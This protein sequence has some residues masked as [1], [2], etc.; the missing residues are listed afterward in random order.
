MEVARERLQG[1]HF[2]KHVVADE[3]GTSA[4][5]FAQPVFVKSLSRVEVIT[6]SQTR[7]LFA[8]CP[9]YTTLFAH[10]SPNTI[11]FGPITLTVYSYT[12]RNTD[13]FLLQ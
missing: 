10:T 5:H 11:L 2:G 8:D 7:R 3:K 12:L 4:V 6:L 9:E 13:T 1:S